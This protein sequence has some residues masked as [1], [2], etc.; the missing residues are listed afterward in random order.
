MFVDEAPITVRAGHGG[1]GMVAFR[2]EKYVPRGGP[3][4]GDGGRGGSI[5][6]LG[7][8]Q[9]TTLLDFRHKRAFAAPNGE[10]GGADN[11]HGKDGDDIIIPVP[12]GTLVYEADQLVADLREDGVRVC[13]ARGGR[14][15]LGNQHFATS[16][17]QAPRYA[18]RGEPGE[19]RA[20]NLQLKLLADAGIVGAPNAGKSTLL[21]SV[22]AARP[23]I[24]DY[25]FTT[26]E[27][28]LGVVQI[29]IDANFVLVDVPGL[30]EGASGGAGLGDKFLR[31]VER[32][33]VLIHLID[34]GLTPDEALAQKAMIEAEL[35][36]WNP[37]L[38]E[39]H[40]ILAVSKMDIPSAVD[41]FA[42]VEAI[43]PDKVFGISA[44]T[45]LGVKPLMAAA[46]AAIV[47]ARAAA[48]TLVE[49]VAGVVLRPKPVSSR[50]RVEVAKEG[51][52]FRVAGAG[53][54]RLATMTDLDSDEGRSFFA[55]ALA[56]SG[57][58]RKLEKLGLRAGDTVRVGAA[59]F[60]FS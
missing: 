51:G 22:S 21:A 47:E 41:V 24:A 34:G 50:R 27:P 48:Q 35:L 49:G 43:S 11:C 17:N 30:I 38:L 32:T 1:N 46:Y 33:R 19:E 9:R 5:Y 25:P 2:R 53:L 45:G 28:Q 12:L 29:D 31:H 14:G 15:G 3:S 16:V 39:K 52:A 6:L 7:D 54:E 26:L 13:V 58:L 18:Q 10:P 4:G 55:R 57:A 8:A 60:I 36:A 44:A 23:K 59:E 37:A 56:R 20:L 40:R 42:A